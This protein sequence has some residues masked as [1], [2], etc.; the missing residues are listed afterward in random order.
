MLML[1]VDIVPTRW[2]VYLSAVIMLIG[3]FW[4]CCGFCI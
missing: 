3:M 2:L 1:D 4:Y